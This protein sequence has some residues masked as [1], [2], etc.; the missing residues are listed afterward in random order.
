MQNKIHFEGLNG[1]RAMAVLA[2]V[3]SHITIHLDFFGLDNGIF[4]YNKNGT[5]MG[6]LAGAY[7]VTIFFTLSG[8]LITYL[9]L[10]E[11]Q[12]QP[13]N[14]RNF[15]MRRVLRI[16][17]LYFLF[18]ILTLFTYLL[19]NIKFELKALLQCMFFAGNVPADIGRKLPLLGHY[20]SLGVEEQ[21]YLF[22]PFF[23][24]YSRN[25]LLRN[26][27]CLAVLL[28]GIR[29]ICWIIY[30]NKGDFSLNFIMGTSRYHLLVFGSIVAILYFQKNEKFINLV[31]KK[32]IQI[33]SWAIFLLF[34]YN[35]VIF[36]LSH[37]LV[38][39]AT[40]CII[41]AQIIGKNKLINLETKVLDFIGRISFGIYITHNL[42]IFYCGKLIGKFVLPN[43]F[44]YIFVYFFVIT[45][46]IFLSDLSYNY[47][48]KKFLR[49]KLQYTIFTNES[50]ETKN[51]DKTITTIY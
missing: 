18:L 8:F 14:I 15:Y 39:V 9:L 16:F 20:W 49:M 43:I 34:C 6:W 1:L 13:V 38:A 4:G 40:G 28:F 22:L 46:V 50:K 24:I 44:S 12:I 42:I 51:N 35:K 11:Q 47:F 17:P 19:F 30:K 3:I 21:F 27:I 45:I 7:G 5:P 37:E 33:L 10:R 25:K 2:V 41:I 32:S 36:P 48:E 23:L 31:T 29:V 26:T